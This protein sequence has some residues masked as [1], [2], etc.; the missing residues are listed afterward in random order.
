MA[1]KIQIVP[2]LLTHSLKEFKDKL[3]KIDKHFP[4]VQIDIMDNEFVDN[5]TYYNFERIRKIRTKADY[6]LHLMVADPQK[7]IKK[8][9]K[10]KKVK[11]VIFHF[12]A[13]KNDDEIFDL[14]KYLKSKKIKAGLAINPETSV[15][16]LE[17]FIPKLSLVFLMG[18]EPGWGG[19]KLKPIVLD[20]AR[21][22][23]KKYPKLDIEIDGG[24]NI[25]NLPAIKK[26]GVNIISA[27]SMIFNSDD[28][29][30]KINQI[31]NI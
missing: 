11:K 28:I 8:W 9:E 13:L 16:V 5:K 24:V 10:F 1:K 30:K 3:K 15:S 23:R 17:K 22:L 2:T 4:L 6:E 25:D 12:E 27:G 31:L 18:V 20:K 29:N 26:S 14:I 21:Y 7:E 19:Q